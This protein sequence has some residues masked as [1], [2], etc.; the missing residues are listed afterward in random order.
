MPDFD[1]LNDAL[2]PF[3]LLRLR[4]V[5]ASDRLLRMPAQQGSTIRGALASSLK[6]LVCV[7]RELPQCQPCPLVEDCAYPYFFETIPPAGTPGTRG[8]EQFPRPYVITYPAQRTPAGRTA[9]PG[10]AGERPPEDGAAEQDEDRANEDPCSRHEIGLT[11]VG[12]AIPLHMYLALAL[13]NLENRGIGAGRTHFGLESIDVLG[14]DGG[15]HQIYDGQSGMLL[16]PEPVT[17]GSEVV[18][19]AT[20]AAR[21]AGGSPAQKAGQRNEARSPGV[22]VRFVSPTALNHQGKAAAVP[23]FHVLVRN[24]IRRISLL[25]VGHCRYRMDLPF[26]DFIAAAEE[27]ELRRVNTRRVSWQR[28]SARQ[29]NRVPMSGFLGE[30]EYDSKALP[31]L[32]L[33]AL[34]SLVHAGDNSA[35]GMGRYLVRLAGAGGGQNGWFPAGWQLAGE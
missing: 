5:L 11:L 14:L 7:R 16:A 33:L 26:G 1:A 3:T 8:F 15:R 35:F 25:S 20:N 34:G 28:H 29:V 13:R 19:E 24:V 4:V 2:C 22:V 9:E 10:A 21:A 23:E 18:K 32:P 31:F 30:V 27:C 12:R 17:T 6:E